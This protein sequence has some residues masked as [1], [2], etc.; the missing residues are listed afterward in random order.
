MEHN[1]ALKQ[2]ADFNRAFFSNTYDMLIMMQDQ[3]EKMTNSFLSQASWLPEESRKMV[4]EWIKACKKGQ[5]DIKKNIDANLK[6][7]EDVFPT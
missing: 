5:E 4:A 1:Q 7:V 6:K 2:I 3:T